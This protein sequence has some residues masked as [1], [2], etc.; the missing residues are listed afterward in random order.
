[1]GIRILWKVQ[2]LRLWPQELRW[3]VAANREDMCWGRKLH[4]TSRAPVLEW[5]HGKPWAH[6]AP[7]TF[8]EHPL[9]PNFVAPEDAKTQGQFW[10]GS[11]PWQKLT[12]LLWVAHSSYHKSRARNKEKTVAGG[13]GSGTQSSHF[14]MS[15]RTKTRTDWR[16]KRAVHSTK[17]SRVRRCTRAGYRGTLQLWKTGRSGCGAESVFNN[18]FINEKT[19]LNTWTIKKKK[20]RLVIEM[21]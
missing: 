20:H 9:L 13:Q 14:F 10:W 7:A 12:G 16:W 2:C 6:S 15:K 21:K 17:V 4:F 5:H 3:R 8:E 19:I 18:L 11:F 1:M